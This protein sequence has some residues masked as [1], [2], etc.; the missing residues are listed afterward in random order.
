[1]PAKKKTPAKTK[2]AK[3]SSLQSKRPARSSSG[4]AKAGSKRKASPSPAPQTKKGV[5]VR[6]GANEREA[7]GPSRYVPVNISYSEIVIT[8]RSRVD[9]KFVV[10][11]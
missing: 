5:G 4:L 7:S 8:K 6:K 9:T 1:M 3:V 2:S 11:Y 10:D